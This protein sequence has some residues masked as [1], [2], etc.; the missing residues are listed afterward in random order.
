MTVTKHHQM[1][2]QGSQHS[3]AVFFHQIWG[4]ES[5]ATLFTPPTSA[6]LQLGQLMWRWSRLRRRLH[7]AM[8]QPLQKHRHS[9][10]VDLT[11]QHRLSL[12]AYQLPG[13]VSRSIVVFTAQVEG[14]SSL[15]WRD[16]GCWT[17]TRVGVAASGDQLL[18]VSRRGHLS[19]MGAEPALWPWHRRLGYV[20]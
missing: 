16:G 10:S 5:L 9:I 15:S 6:P 3:K 8:A 14:S 17:G 18:L 12:P 11:P 13:E 4:R 7:C 20:H 2:T 1:S 19:W